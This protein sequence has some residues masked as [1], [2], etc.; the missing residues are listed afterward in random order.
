[1][2]ANGN[3]CFIFHYDASA[4]AGLPLRDFEA[5]LEAEGIPM[6]VSYP[7]LGDLELFAGDERPPLPVA[8][9]AAATTVWLQ[10][11]MLL[12]RRESVLDVARAVEKVQ[13]GAAEL[14]ERSA[15]V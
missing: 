9:N 5:A 4:F 12:A 8:V 7:S 1:M 14:V 10:H 6:G 15:T 11:R 2:D 3:Y 13:A